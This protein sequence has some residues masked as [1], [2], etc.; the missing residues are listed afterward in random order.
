M[1]GL[2]RCPKCRSTTFDLV[3]VFEEIETRAVVDGVV[4]KE[5]DHTPGS[6]IATSCECAC[7]HKWT[8]RESSLDALERE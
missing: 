1:S 4:S 8:P 3:E 7:G 5:S 2:M 6:L